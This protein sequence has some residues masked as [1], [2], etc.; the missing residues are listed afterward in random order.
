MIKLVDANRKRFVMFLGLSAAVLT[1]AGVIF[2]DTFSADGVLA[3]RSVETGLGYWTA[4]T[5]LTVPNGVALP[6]K[7]V[8]K[9]WAANG[10]LPFVPEAGHVYILSADVHVVSGSWGAIGFV[11]KPL[12]YGSEKFWKLSET[13]SPWM[14]VNAVG[15]IYTFSGP[16][17]AGQQVFYGGGASGVMVI[18]LDTTSVDWVA[19][20]IY[21]G[22]PFRTEAYD[23]ALDITGVAFGAVGVANVEVENFKLEVSD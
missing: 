7:G 12:T 3:S 22:K 20:Y 16:I 18:K 23:G 4:D 1:Q 9:N 15:T 8:Q 2:E 11:S 21:Q 17:T 13:A 5:S 19:M 6:A 10:I 14:Y